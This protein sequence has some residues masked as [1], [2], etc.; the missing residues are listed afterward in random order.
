MCSRYTL[1]TIDG[2][3]ERF[4][5][6][7]PP[8][9]CRRGYNVAPGRTMPVIA[10][11][12]RNEV[13]MMRWGLVPHWAKDERAIQHPANAR[14]ETLA[15]KPMFKNLLKNY[16]CLVPATGFYEWKKDGFRRV[17]YYIR[18]RETPFIAFAG[19]YDIWSDPQGLEH[20]TYTIIT[21]GSNELV[22]SIHDRM[23]VILKR[24][25]ERRWLS[26][27]LLTGPD[28][29]GILAPYPGGDMEAYPVGGRLNDVTIDEENLIRPLGQLF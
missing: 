26:G 1:V 6:I 23:P 16:R 8:A 9:G 24:E 12:E 21:T 28:L 17:P 11:K 14:V 7:C 15:D 20:Q 22:A 29:R 25:D 19:L 18:V 2:F 27:S 10:L 3:N 5:V 13:V 4:Q